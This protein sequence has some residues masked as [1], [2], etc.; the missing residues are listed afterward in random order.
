MFYDTPV[1][2]SYID[3]T[4]IGPEGLWRVEL[5]EDNKFELIHG[6][7]D[8][9]LG[10]LNGDPWLCQK[11]M[12]KKHKHWKQQKEEQFEF[13]SLNKNSPEDYTQQID[14]KI[15]LGNVSL[16][17]KKTLK[18]VDQEFDQKGEEC[19]DIVFSKK[20]QMGELDHYSFIFLDQK[21]QAKYGF[22][23]NQIQ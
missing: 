4:E 1:L 14:F 6:F 22:I 5:L 2:E 18:V 8:Q 12:E 3:P 15:K 13:K 23:F 17:N 21:E 19:Y 20:G 9:K 11:H 7:S 16:R 10:T